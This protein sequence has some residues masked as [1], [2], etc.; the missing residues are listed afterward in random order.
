MIDLLQLPAIVNMMLFA[1]AAAGVWIAGTRLSIYA[2]EI[3][4]RRRI[5]KALMG[6]IFLAGAT[7]L[8]EIVT[9]L[10]ASLENNAA[11][12][13]NNLFGGIA[14]QTAILAAADSAVRN[15]PLTH[16]P[17]KLTPVLEA[18]SLVILLA[19]L[20][21]LIILGDRQ[22]GLQVGVGTAILIGAYL[23][24]I[25]FLRRFDKRDAWRPVVLPEESDVDDGLGW[26]A[27]VR[28]VTSPMLTVGFVLA[29]TA[30]LGFG[31]LLVE[32]S[33]ALA[34]QTGL[35]S[36]FIG[37]TLLAA[38]TS[39]P[40]LSTTIMAVRLR[41]YTMAI[42]NIFGSNL[43]MVALVLPADILYRPGP[44]LA[45]VDPTAAFAII[46]GLLVTM[47]YII[48]LVV[49]SRRQLFGLGLDSAIVLVIYL[50]SLVAFYNLR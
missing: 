29:A 12:A 4:D 10:T 39:L 32:T 6:L 45:E 18:S 27:R 48:G 2:E 21:A 42:S 35:G 47:V 11:L 1:A 50:L 9:T 44:I 13:L 49:R 24:A 5:G 28:D 26:I 31:V 36:S 3:S 19:L 33:D 16:F 40:E 15:A 41:S 23:S 17:R 7:S 25:Y 14:L 38:S 34:V 43:I 30:V 46:S 22:L 37:V 8:P 20:Q